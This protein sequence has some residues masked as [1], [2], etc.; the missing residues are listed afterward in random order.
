[1]KPRRF[2]IVVFLMVGFCLLLTSA[3][4]AQDRQT[5]AVKPGDTLWGIS[6]H[7]YGDETLWP[8]LWE[9]NR[10]HTTN[11]HQIYVGDVLT[12]Y[13]IEE[14]MKAAAGQAP[15]PARGAAYDA[16]VP[17]NTAFP[18]Y[19]TF[20]SGQDSNNP[21]R[22]K[23]K[24]IDHVTGKPVVTYDEVREVGEIVA[25][26]ERG[27][28]VDS[29]VIHGRLMLSYY[30]DVM[31]RFSQDVARI[32]DSASHNDP[33]PYFRSFPIYSVTNEVTEPDTGRVDAGETIGS[34]HEFKGILTVVAR[35][36]GLA[37]LSEKAQKK[38]ATSS[39][40]YTEGDA[41]S[42]VAKITYSAVPIGIG[43][44]IFLFKTL[45]P[46]PDRDVKP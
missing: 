8:K 2:R 5:Y 19:F 23:V 29:G 13:P 10:Y 14:L 46:G 36:E 4:V 27:Q 37:P 26:M 16:G 15:P 17:L 6:K 45:E 11:P 32:L 3:A 22:I 7:F 43:D 30:D 40:S 18:K 44:R 39:G 31:V 42:Y 21:T 25:S 20:L 24:K 9:L 35:V 12:I 28:P 33:D 41:V 34:L 1:M 38:L